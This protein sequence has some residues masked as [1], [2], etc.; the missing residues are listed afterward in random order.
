VEEGW[1]PTAGSCTWME[2][3]SFMAVWMSTCLSIWV[4]NS[5][6]GIEELTSLFLSSTLWQVV[7]TPHAPPSS[8][9]V[10]TAE[11]K[12]RIS[13]MLSSNLLVRI[14]RPSL[15]KFM[16]MNNHHLALPFQILLRQCPDLDLFWVYGPWTK[17]SAVLLWRRH[18]RLQGNY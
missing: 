17:L 2:L 1:R 3:L 16:G 13:A 11:C 6:E 8:E 12:R 9:C 7:R 4:T 18:P 5:V 10:C 14:S 15:K